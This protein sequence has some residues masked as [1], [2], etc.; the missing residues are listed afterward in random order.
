MGR[1]DR[2]EKRKKKQ[3]TSQKLPSLLPCVPPP[4]LATVTLK[5]LV[6]HFGI[7]SES[8]LNLLSDMIIWH[9]SASCCYN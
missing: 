3:L 8:G 5:L 7:I 4:P 1:K 9:K 6:E 2:T